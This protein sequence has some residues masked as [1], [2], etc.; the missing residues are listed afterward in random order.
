MN[1]RRLVRCKSRT[2]SKCPKNGTMKTMHRL[3]GGGS[4][5]EHGLE[6]NRMEPTGHGLRNGSDQPSSARRGTPAIFIVQRLQQRIRRRG[7][8]CH[9]ATARPLRSSRPTSIPAARDRGARS[10]VPSGEALCIYI[11]V[12]AGERGGGGFCFVLVLLV[13]LWSLDVVRCCCDYLVLL[14]GG[15]LIG[16]RFW[17]RSRVGQFFLGGGTSTGAP[18]IPDALQFI[19]AFRY[20]IVWYGMV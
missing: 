19:E 18:S 5:H 4:I 9:R 1:N 15:C 13:G 12:E 16:Y 11:P 14:F 10:T 7:I 8:L 2:F 6:H 3:A 20:G 17:A